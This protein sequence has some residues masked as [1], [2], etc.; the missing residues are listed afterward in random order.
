MP[1]GKVAGVPEKCDGCG[2][3]LMYA[4]EGATFSREEGHV[5]PGTYDGVLFWT[6]PDCGRARHRWPEGSTL[7]RIAEQKI[8]LLPEKGMAG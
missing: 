1:R 6:C 2:A 8:L 7:H 3:F 4:Y 5:F